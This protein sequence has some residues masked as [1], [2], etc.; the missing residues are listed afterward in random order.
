MGKKLFAMQMN[1]ASM[2]PLFP[3]NTL[4]IFDSEITPKDRCYIALKRYEQQ[5][6]IFRQF[7]VDGDDFYIKPL[8][9]DF[10]NFIM[11]NL[12]CEDMILGVLIQARMDY[13]NI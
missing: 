5:K 4:L 9:P 13:I 1:D 2:E 7:L 3:Q 8:S 6:V 12:N 11:T 10:V